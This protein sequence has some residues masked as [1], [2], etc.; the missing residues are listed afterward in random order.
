MFVSCGSVLAYFSYII[1]TKKRN[2][3]R[4]IKETQT[5]I[6]E[7][8]DSNAIYQGDYLYI[9]KPHYFIPNILMEDELPNRN[10]RMPTGLPH[11]DEEVPPDIQYWDQGID[12]ANDDEEMPA[13][14]L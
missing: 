3:D 12:F 11:V 7:N 6:E 10:L 4:K 2:T 8:F 1:I 9:G 5:D 14:L 13:D